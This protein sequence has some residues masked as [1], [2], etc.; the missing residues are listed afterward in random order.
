[1]KLIFVSQYFPPE[2]GAAASRGYDLL[3]EFIKKEHKVT[4]LTE[5]PHYPSSV[6][7]EKY[8]N[9]LFY[10][11]KFNNIDVIRNF[12]FVSKRSNFFQRSAL[13]FSFMF[14]SVF[15]S[16]GINDIDIVFATSPPLTVGLAGWVISKFK[17]SKFVLDIRDLWPESALALGEIK[18]GIVSGILKK[19]EL[20]LYRKADLITIAVPGFRKHINGLGISDNKIIDLP[21]GANVELFSSTPNSD[22]TRK[23]FGWENKFLVLFSGNHGLAQG[24]EYL[25][26][27]ADSMKNIEN[28]RFIFI[29]DGVVKEKLIKMKTEMKLDSVTFLDK[30]DR[31]QM[32]SFISAMDVCLVP[33]IKHRLFL[34]ALPSKMFEYMACE[35]P[36]IVAIEGEA[37]ELIEK[38]GA[39]IFVEPENV[40]QM[41][42]AIFN[43]YN[44]KK[45]RIKMGK[46]G[47]KFVSRDY[48][49]VE[50]AKKFETVLKDLVSK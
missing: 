2:V 47:R 20:F 50:I 18:E 28:I 1:M 45:L 21:N 46:K 36:V 44:N 49:R 27:I 26:K 40:S 37:K 38:S 11:E 35:K 19:I 6:V 16:K 34:N 41:K 3:Q 4:V 10:R 22:K 42:D 29:G 17:K 9:S 12:V 32:P 24:L 33:L 48:C 14:T 31:D 25:L 30:V 13:Y 39:G 15:G 5:L 7:D 23:Q 43:L 8:K